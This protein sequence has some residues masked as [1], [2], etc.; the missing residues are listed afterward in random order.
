[1]CV[2]AAL[3]RLPVVAARI[4]GLP[5]ALRDGDHALLFAP[6]DAD[7]CARALAATLQR[8][9]AADA[10]ARRAFGHVQRFSVER[11]VAAEEAFIEEAVGVM[12]R[13]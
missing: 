2:E 5:E 9:A 3:A 1:V 4:G 7:A 12:G 13:G 10:R 6:G 11:F 8:P